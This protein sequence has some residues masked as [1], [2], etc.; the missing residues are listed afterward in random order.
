MK[1]GS[2]LDFVIDSLPCES[3]YGKTGNL[4]NTKIFFCFISVK[5][6]ND[7]YVFSFLCIIRMILSL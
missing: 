4:A 3:S 6:R 1:A 7:T 2:D 5:D